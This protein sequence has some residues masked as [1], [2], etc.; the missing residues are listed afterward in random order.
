MKFHWTENVFWYR[1]SITQ[2]LCGFSSVFDAYIY[3]MI[4]WFNWQISSLMGLVCAPF[5]FTVLSF[6]FSASFVGVVVLWSM[7]KW[8]NQIFPLTVPPFSYL[9]FGKWNFRLFE[10]LPI[11]KSWLKTK[12][13]TSLTITWCE[14]PLHWTVWLERSLCC[15]N[16]VRIVLSWMAIYA[17]A[18]WLAGSDTNVYDYMWAC[19]LHLAFKC[20]IYNHKYLSKNKCKP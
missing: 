18:S 17:G 6:S 4:M 13:P 14:I 10:R 20:Y 16:I 9:D 15:S 7:S 3:M 19:A 1:K 12:P 11:V 5:F 2:K 8:D